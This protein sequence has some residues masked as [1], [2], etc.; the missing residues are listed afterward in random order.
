MYSSLQPSPLKRTR[1]AR[2]VLVKANSFLSSGA[3]AAAAEEE[4]KLELEKLKAE[5]AAKAAEDAAAKAGSSWGMMDADEEIAE[6]QR[7]FECSPVAVDR[8]LKRRVL[9]GLVDSGVWD[10]KSPEWT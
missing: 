4:A 8:R 7:A 1:A 6:R 5:R 9:V 3:G 10:S 2:T